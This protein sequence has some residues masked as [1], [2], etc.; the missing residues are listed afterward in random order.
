MTDEAGQIST[1]SCEVQADVR[2]SGFPIFVGAYGGKERLF[3]EEP[4]Y[5]NGRCAAL[6]G[7]EVGIQP[8]IAGTPSS[9]PR[10]A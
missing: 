7:A 3:Q 6:I 5:P 4:F 10:S 8:K 9:R 2:G 1:N